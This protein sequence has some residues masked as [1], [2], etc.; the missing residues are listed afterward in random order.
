MKR[1]CGELHMSFPF[2]KRILVPI[3]VLPGLTCVAA[4]AEVPY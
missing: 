1:H 2:T 3:F 4:G